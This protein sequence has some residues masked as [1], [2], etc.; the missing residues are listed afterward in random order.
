MH[1]ARRCYKW[2]PADKS[3][4]G[5]FYVKHFW[6]AD[7][8]ACSKTGMEMRVELKDERTSSLECDIVERSRVELVVA[9]GVFRL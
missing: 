6:I 9:V 3:K 2:V 5:R 4:S 7:S 8:L 1:I